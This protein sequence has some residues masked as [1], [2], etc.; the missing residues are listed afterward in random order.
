VGTTVE[1]KPRGAFA[2]VTDMVGGGAFSLAP[3]QWTDDTSMALCLATSL[4]ECGGFDAQDQMTRYV[5]WWKEGYF[6]STGAC[7]DIGGATSSALGRFLR[8][9]EPYSGSVDPHT[10]GNGSL[11]RLAPVP[12]YYFPDR[13]AAIRYAGESSRTTHGAAE[14]VDACRLFA[15]ML[16]DALAG[17]SKEDILFAVRSELDD[18]APSIAAL[19]AG[20][21][22]AKTEAGISSSG[23]AVHSLEAAL[24]CF[25]TTDSYAEAVLRAANLGHDADTTAAVCGQLAGAAYGLSAIPDHWL[26]RLAM[27]DTIQELA[28]RLH[29]AQP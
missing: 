13:E 28:D 15:V 5:R 6:S 14:A 24:W 9:G 8:A 19:A 27:R 1:F 11:M 22:R 10:A 26:S 2:P 7:F 17:A 23:Y 4:V 12:M 16:V 25:Y 3:G 20:A 21:Y 29:V 18:L